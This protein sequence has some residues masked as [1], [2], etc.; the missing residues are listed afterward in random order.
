[1]KGNE[2]GGSIQ[3]N[4]AQTF[5]GLPTLERSGSEHRVGRFPSSSLRFLSPTR[6]TRLLK[7]TEMRGGAFLNGKEGLVGFRKSLYQ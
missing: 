7:K 4:L 2:L 3:H 6:G 1:M 5:D